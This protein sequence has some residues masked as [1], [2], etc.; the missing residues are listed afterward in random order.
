MELTISKRNEPGLRAILRATD[1]GVDR[2]C[3][4]L[5][6]A[7]PTLFVRDL[8]DR[9]AA[10]AKVLQPQVRAILEALAGL[11]LLMEERGTNEGETADAILAAI[12]R[13]GSEDLRPSAEEK[14]CFRERMI[15]L[16]SLGSVLGT[17]AKALDVMLQHERLYCRARVLT[18]LRPIFPFG[19]EGG[20][21]GF[22]I[23]HD[24]VIRYHGEGEGNQ[25]H[26]TFH[27][28]LSREDIDDLMGVLEQAKHKESSIKAALIANALP[29]MGG[30]ETNA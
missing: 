7:T 27:L 25:S 4:T 10:E 19:S 13:K 5:Q 20:P 18:D 29:I 1:E 8:A 30:E 6:A 16:L 26:R 14:R 24:L 3:E 2:I 9:V 17:T 15:R 22:V 11:Y 21:V 23:T 12:E 28:S